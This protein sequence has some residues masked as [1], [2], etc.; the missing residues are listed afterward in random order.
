M[1]LQAYTLSG[2][3]QQLHFQH[4]RLAA[5]YAMPLCWPIPLARDNLFVQQRKLQESSR[6]QTMV[7]SI[8]KLEKSFEVN[9]YAQAG[10]VLFQQ[11]CNMHM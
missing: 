6:Y 7:E 9:P 11:R 2:S 5:K 10:F 8:S 1:F 4:V 3:T